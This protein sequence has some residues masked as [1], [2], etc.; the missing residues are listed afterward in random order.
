MEEL[1]GEISPGWLLTFGVLIVQVLKTAFKWEDLK[2][3]FLSLVVAYVLIFPYTIIRGFIDTPPVAIWDSLW[4]TYKACIY[5]LPFWLT[6][7]G[8]YTVVLKPIASRL[9]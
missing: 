6:M 3:L 8:A 7:I 4:L 9:K 2:A 5:P 1:F